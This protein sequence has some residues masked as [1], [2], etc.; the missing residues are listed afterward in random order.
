MTYAT[1]FLHHADTKK[2]Q[3]DRANF[4]RQLGFRRLGLFVYNDK[5]E[6]DEEQKHR[7]WGILSGVKNQDIFVHQYPSGN[8]ERYESLLL[9]EVRWKTGKLGIWIDDFE[10][11]EDAP[12]G[13]RAHLDAADFYIVKDAVERERLATDKP[14]FTYEFSDI[15]IP[16]FENITTFAPKVLNAFDA[17]D[18]V[19]HLQDDVFAEKQFTG[20]GL[21]DKVDNYVISKFL[22]R[23]LPL[24]IQKDLPEAAWI[25]RNQ[26][27]FAYRD[28]ADLDH[29]LATITKTEY[30]AMMNQTKHFSGLVRDGFFTK[31]V[32]SQLEALEFLDIKKGIPQISF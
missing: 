27:G 30:E 32:L 24:A 9:Q 6:S 17:R 1:G 23:Q 2:R 28:Q 10:A 5:G 4:A 19:T 26:L 3:E 21:V 31:K 14:V 18:G 8:S 11:F 16:I 29:Q 13:L 20:Y 22:V 12:D 15:D 25:V 7:I